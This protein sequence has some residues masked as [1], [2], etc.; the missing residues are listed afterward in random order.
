MKKV[1]RE[2]IVLIKS[3]EGFRPRSVARPEGGWIIGYG[4]TLSAREGAT[5]SEADAELLLRYDLLQIEKRLNETAADRLNQHQ[6]DALV[7]F[8]FSVGLEAFEASD[9][10]SKLSAGEASA[11]AEAMLGWP[12]T[13]SPSAGARRRTAERALFTADPS[14]PVALAELLAA[15]VAEQS[16]MV[17]HEAPVEA[18]E[19]LADKAAPIEPTD[20]T[21]PSA[22]AA[23]TSLGE[24]TLEDRV[25]QA[26]PAPVEPLV[27]AVAA[28][29]GEM[30]GTPVGPAAA[31]I[32]PTF[33]APSIPAPSAPER[34][35]VTAEAVVPVEPSATADADISVHAEAPAEVEHAVKVEAPVEVEAT[36]LAE[37]TSTGVEPEPH[38]ERHAAANSVEP[39]IASEPVVPAAKPDASAVAEPVLEVA[40][41]VPS[42]ALAVGMVGERSV[43]T[44][45]LNAQRYSPYGAPIIGPLPFLAPAEPAEPTEATETAESL[46]LTSPED[47][48]APLVVRPAWTAEER[49]EVDAA[50]AGESLFG[51]DLSLTQGGQPLGR[52]D[53]EPE[54]PERFDWSETGAFVVMGAVGLTA[55]GAS[56][57]AFR[58]ASE[59]G[60]GDETSIIGWVL[61][62]IGVACVGV[63]SFNLYRKFGLAGS[64]R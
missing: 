25:A 39:A 38:D 11:A 49:A 54:A 5:V 19:P 64:D 2:G 37:A 20:R 28:L 60:G 1:S 23:E 40:A 27:A 34:A 50:P 35:E 33:E 12:E 58:L 3:F 31:P 59:Q 6:F 56:M 8:A 4:H 14:R 10:L 24:R 63:S 45:A 62:V 47:A 29:L 36:G 13:R 51:E 15:P 42:E 32:V 22:A 16:T 46:V 55:F 17:A 44:I 52:P 57:A 43:S 30:D 26:E 21:E 9:V 53:F 48:P 61:A 7:S 41:E 18:A